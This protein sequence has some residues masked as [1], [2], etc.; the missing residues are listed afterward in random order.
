MT[1]EKSS[2]V[3]MKDENKEAES[4]EKT[5]EEKD[6]ISFDGKVVKQRLFAEPSSVIFENLE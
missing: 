5:Q 3:E 1:T 6:A 4:V 2:D